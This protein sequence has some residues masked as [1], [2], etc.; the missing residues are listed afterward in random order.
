MALRR[1]LVRRLRLPLRVL[2]GQQQLLV[3]LRQELLLGV[4][5][6]GERLRLKLGRRQ[7]VEL[8]LWVH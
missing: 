5:L 8:R 1:V 4:E 3:R 7:Q 6:L 2:L